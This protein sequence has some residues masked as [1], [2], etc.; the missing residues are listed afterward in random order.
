MNRIATALLFSAANFPAAVLAQ[1]PETTDD[2]SRLG[3]IVVTAERRAVNMQDVPVAVTNISNDLAN[4]LAV[5]SVTDIQVAAPAVNW[6]TGTGGA[7]ISVRGVSGTGSTG[8]EPANAVYVDGVYNPV[9]ASLLFQFNNIERIEIDKGPQGTLFGRNASGGAIQI[10]TRDPQQ[11]PTADF[12]I[13][14]GNY[15]TIEARGYVSMGIASNLAA[16]LALFYSN[17]GNGW[18]DNFTTGS[19]AY[20]GRNYGIRTKW[21]WTPS[22]AMSFVFIY[23]HNS[24]QPSPQNGPGQILPGQGRPYA[25]FFN[26][27]AN[28]DFYQKAIQ[29]NVSLN[30]SFDLG[31]VTLRSI[32]AYDYVNQPLEFD[33]D[34]G[35]APAARLLPGAKTYGKAFSQE[36]QLLSP[37]GSR[38]SW[39]LGF[40]YFDSVNFRHSEVVTPAFVGVQVNEGRSPAK[41]YA[42]F[43]QATVP[44]GESTRLTGGLRYTID[45]RKLEGLLTRNGVVLAD[46][47]PSVA[48][49]TD[50][51]LTWRAS[52]DHDLSE[53]L[54][55]YA[56]VTRGFKSGFYNVSAVTNPVLEPQVVDAYEIGFKSEFLDNRVRL[57]PSAFLY[58]LSDL[59]V[60][61]VTPTGPVFQNA[62][63][64]R[65]KGLDLDLQ[66]RPVRALTIQGGLTY[67]HAKYLDF[68][69]APF[70]AINPA[71][72]IIALPAQ[73]ARGKYL[74]RAPK[75]SASIGGQYKIETGSDSS[76]TLAANLYHNAGM[77]FDPQNRARQPHYNL[78]SGSVSWAPNDNL[79]IM[80][81]GKNLADERYYSTIDV[82][83][84]TGD[85]YIPAAPRTYGATFRARF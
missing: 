39:V 43:G 21:K 66:A 5:K 24:L 59:Q 12:S 79:E 71:G 62:A 46:I 9:G 78:V 55:V 29:D 67:L 57:N 85:V 27:F 56:S 38:I 82:T 74:T 2:S 42:A 14:Y 13:G 53:D 48:N 11:T 25:G 75:F 83:V 28:V 77:F 6:G 40:F 84:P 81:W 68:P 32:T 70:S 52:I 73:N 4:A 18:G 80:L 41:S 69:G 72:G 37:T 51:K 3:E 47:D 8:D 31:R 65:I 7:N 34:F 17:Q 61:Q 76:I 49:N 60:R 26:S 23:S 16:D 10:F 64:G 54:L 45:K 1:A 20:L 19:E 36:L 44:L 30:A 50:K 22:D 58:D 33:L 35:A 63:R 15:N